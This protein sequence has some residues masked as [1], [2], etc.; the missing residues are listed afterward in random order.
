MSQD[1]VNVACKKGI[2]VAHELFTIH[3]VPQEQNKNIG[4]LDTAKILSSNE[5]SL[6]CTVLF[7]NTLNAVFVCACVQFF[8]L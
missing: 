8:F 6:I 5:H 4:A 1:A 2:A 3:A 7:L